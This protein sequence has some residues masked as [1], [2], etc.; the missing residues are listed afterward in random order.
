MPWKA[1]EDICKSGSEFAR[2]ISVHNERDNAMVT[3][4]SWGG[5]TWIGLEI[6][7]ENDY[8]WSDGSNLDYQAWKEGG[9]LFL[10][11]FFFVRLKKKYFFCSL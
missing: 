6:R 8:H 2:L 7:G 1:A 4:E 9:N 5:D 10:F 11:K 3:D